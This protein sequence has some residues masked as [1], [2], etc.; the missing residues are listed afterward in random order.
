[1]TEER[2]VGGRFQLV[3][4]LTLASPLEPGFP[5]AAFRVFNQKFA[6]GPS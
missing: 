5:A 2:S 6:W 3:V 4:L 1:M